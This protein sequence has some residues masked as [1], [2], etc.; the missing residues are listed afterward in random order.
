LGFKKRKSN[1]QIGEYLEREVVLGN[2]LQGDGGFGHVEIQFLS[3]S[4]KIE[5]INLQ[6]S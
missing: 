2:Q 5:Q 3:A 6:L 1:L 4:L